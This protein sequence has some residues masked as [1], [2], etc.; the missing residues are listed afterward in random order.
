[1][2]AGDT[3]SWAY[4]LY[5]EAL[6]SNNATFDMSP[7]HSMLKSD[8]MKT[9][10]IYNWII[11]RIQR[12]KSFSF[13]HYPLPPCDSVKYIT[14]WWMGRGWVKRSE[15]QRSCFLAGLVFFLFFFFLFLNPCDSH[16]TASL[17]NDLVVL[18]K[19]AVDSLPISDFKLGDNIHILETMVLFCKEAK[20]ASTLCHHGT[21]GWTE[22][23][24]ECCLGT[25]PPRDGSWWLI[26]FNEIVFKQ[27]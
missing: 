3:G 15:V 25:L 17:G 19:I 23:S 10:R 6:L 14:G 11:Y 16:Q 7:F 13:S 27:D 9:T 24:S 21:E 22:E 2:L 4:T 8:D 26:I 20:K 1:M 5:K 18:D 12:P